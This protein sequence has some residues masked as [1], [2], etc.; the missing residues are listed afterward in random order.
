MARFVR[1]QITR[2]R[3]NNE[4]QSGALRGMHVILYRGYL[5][6]DVRA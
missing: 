2:S 1:G 6:L 5:A 3:R 4:M